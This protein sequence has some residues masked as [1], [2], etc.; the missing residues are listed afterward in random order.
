MVTSMARAR[1]TI[2]ALLAEAAERWPTSPYVLG[3]TGEDYEAWTFSEMRERARAFAAYLVD[4]GFQPGQTLGLL[5]EGRPEWVAAELGA[6]L[7]GLVS[8]PLSTKLT[9]SELAF[10]LEHAEVSAVVVSSLARSAFDKAFAIG[11]ARQAPPVRVI[12]LG[13]PPKNLSDGET[14]F[15]SAI[16]QGSRALRA[17]GSSMTSRLAEIE[18]SIESDSLASICYTSGTMGN[19]KGIELTHGNYWANAWD[20]NRL[21]DNPEGLRALMMLPVDHSFTHTVAI[22]TALTCGVALYFVDA[23]GGSMGLVRNIPRNIHESRP[24]FMFTVPVLSAVFKRRIEEGVARRGPAIAKL[25][26]SCLE[27]AYAWMGDGFHKPPLMNR[28]KVLAPYLAGSLFLFPLVRRE[29]FG[30]SIRFCVSGGAMLDTGQQ[31]FFA[32]LGA[33]FHQGYGLTEAAPVVASNTPRKHKFGTVG[34]PAPSVRCRIL[35]DDGAELPP[36]CV[37]EIAVR[38]PNI[39]RGYRNNPQATAEAIRDGELRTGDL[40]YIDADGFLVVVGRK[41]ALLVSEDGEKYSPEPIEEAILASTDIVRQI[42]VWC[43]YKKL[44]CAL[45]ELDTERFRTLIEGKGI[46]TASGALDVL[47]TKLASACSLAAVSGLQKSWLP[48]SFQIVPQG[49]GEADGTLNSTLK[50]VRPRVETVHRDL[51]EYAYTTEGGSTDNPRN[52]RLL[53][54]MFG[55]PG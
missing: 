19:P 50:I 49:F 16:E 41:R 28:L 22:F 55:L 32:A 40:G 33:P 43:V 21:F 29:A 7:A 17:S 45:I 4:E 44:P 54:S 37:G 18:G 42:L 51:I 48:A 46:A 6:L 14:D 13:K 2:P 53:A 3:K 20:S 12:S 35:A 36:A 31:K 27:A 52:L 24:H 30:D 1:H 26:Q 10:R 38:G 47:R 15:D 23:R 25:F 39:M 8:V 9:P 34:I 11:S 5:G